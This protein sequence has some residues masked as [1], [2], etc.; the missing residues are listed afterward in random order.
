MWG[1]L[2]LG[3]VDAAAASVNNE[4]KNNAMIIQ[5]QQQNVQNQYQLAMEQERTRQQ[6][7]ETKRAIIGGVFNVLAAA[8]AASGTNANSNKNS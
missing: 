6:K 4:A 7:E 1:T 5:G 2:L 8:A 3:L